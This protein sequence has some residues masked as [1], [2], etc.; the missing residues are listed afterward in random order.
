MEINDQHLL[1]LLGAQKRYSFREIAAS[2]GKSIGTVQ[3]RMNE[4]VIEEYLIKPQ[5]SVE[6]S[7]A[8]GYRLTQKGIDVLRKNN[9]I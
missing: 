8:R 9:L 6:R 4:L 5:K 1:T 7:A 3:H 2:L